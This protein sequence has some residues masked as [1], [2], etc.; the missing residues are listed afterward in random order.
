MGGL[1]MGLVKQILMKIT[2]SLILLAVAI[3][4]GVAYYIGK[5][6]ALA[7][8]AKGYIPDVKNHTDG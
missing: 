2:Y 7:E 3:F 8:I 1:D 6:I 5:Y 4:F